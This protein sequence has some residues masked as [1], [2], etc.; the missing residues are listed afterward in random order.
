MNILR[1]KVLSKAHLSQNQ[2]GKD[3]RSCMCNSS[4]QEWA[5]RPLSLWELGE[6]SQWRHLCGTPEK[7]CAFSGR[8]GDYGCYR[9][10]GWHVQWQ[11]GKHM[12]LADPSGWEVGVC[13]QARGRNGESETGKTELSHGEKNWSFIGSPEGN[14]KCPA[15]SLVTQVKEKKCAYGGR[16]GAERFHTNISL[17][18]NIA[19]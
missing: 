12:T 13:N 17:V 19:F 15:F 4:T 5:T 1:I 9:E 8:E 10:W 7:G 11:R 14:P 16:P 18:T 3:E 6:A 2:N